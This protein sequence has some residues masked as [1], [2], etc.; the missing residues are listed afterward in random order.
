MWSAGG[1]LAAILLGGALL[2]STDGE[3]VQL[4]GWPAAVL[5]EACWTKQWL[6]W[7]C[8]LC[9]TTRSVILL[10]RGRWQDSWQR[11]PGGILTVVAGLATVALTVLSGPGRWL[12]TRTAGWLVQTLWIGLFVLLVGRHAWLMIPGSQSPAKSAPAHAAVRPIR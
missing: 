9:G 1:L 11:H 6:G 12:T 5:P 10:M 2:E 8:P 4:R 7:S 3:R